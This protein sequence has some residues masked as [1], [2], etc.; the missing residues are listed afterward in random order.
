M[1]TT[2]I[3][4]PSLTC[5]SYLRIVTFY[6]AYSQI[7]TYVQS[8]VAVWTFPYHIESRDYRDCA[9]CMYLIKQILDIYTPNLTYSIVSMEI[10]LLF[11][12]TYCQFLVL[13]HGEVRVPCRHDSAYFIIFDTHTYKYIYIYTYIYIYS[14]TTSNTLILQLLQLRQIYIFSHV[15]NLHLPIYSRAKCVNLQCVIHAF[16][17]S[18]CSRTL[19]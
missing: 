12:A 19:H 7:F 6:L 15:R 17:H 10:S 18:A 16:I 2:T 8:L 4:F 9:Y 11:S 1:L 5:R 14:L 13:C 3:T